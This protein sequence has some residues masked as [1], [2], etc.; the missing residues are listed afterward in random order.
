MSGSLYT[1]LSALNAHQGWLDVIGNNLANTNTPG[2]KSSSATFGDA[3]SR[4]LQPAMSAGKGGATNPMQIGGGVAMGAITRNF[5]Q[6]ALSQTGRTFDLAIGGRGFFSL[7]NGQTDLYTRVGS[8]G[9]DSSSS[10]I[11]L[12]SGYQVLSRSGQPVSLDTE[13]VFPPKATSSMSISGNLPAEVGGPFAAVLTGSTPFREGTPAML[14]G[15]ETAPFTIPAGETW[16]MEITVNGGAPQSVAIQGTGAPVTMQDVATAIDALDHVKATINGG[17]IELSTSVAGATASL[18]ISPGA[19]GQD[20]ALACG[21]STNLVTGSETEV[22]A[23]TDLSSLPGGSG[24]YVSGDSIEISGV[25]VDGEPINSTFV[26][27]ANGTTVGEFVS[28]VDALYPG[29]TAALNANGQLSLSADTAGATELSIS[30]SD[31]AENVGGTQWSD[32]LPVVTTAGTNADRIVTSSELFDSSGVSHQLTMTFERTEDGSWTMTAEASAEEG[33]VTSGPITGLTFDENGAP[34]NQAAIGA[35]V[36]VD[37]SE[38]GSQT[39]SLDLGTDGQLDGLTQFGDTAT[40]RISSQ[41]GYGAGEL[42]TIS[43]ES[44][45]SIFGHY[46]N[47][48]QQTLGEVG[49][50]VFGN[51]EGLEAVGGNLW[52]QSVA[53]GDASLGGGD[54]GA[55]GVVIGG[56]LEQSNVDTAEEFVHLIEAQRGYQASARVISVQD[57]LL[58]DA[59][60]M[61]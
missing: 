13:S 9:L 3:F 37:W 39:A 44:D 15:A 50:A 41:D 31:G 45:G 52:R 5:G 61:L 18:Q 48:Q 16:T 57:E 58:S 14:T 27:G 22:S 32:Y 10:L 26:Y 11:D 46:S 24:E 47:G 55:A 2:Y 49:V 8:F 21:F 53:S 4:N 43:I 7:S 17:A 34:L 12:A 19:A 29:A 59:V 25:G 33:M 40:A 36:T 35:S 42:G 38:G 56:A 60:N 6:G 51:P 20:I 54:L 30:I 23:T 28:Y 1:A